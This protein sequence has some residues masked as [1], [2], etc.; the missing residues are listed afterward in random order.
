MDCLGE[1]L[2]VSEVSRHT[3]LGDV[4]DI[5]CGPSSLMEGESCTLPVVPLAGVVVFPGMIFPLLFGGNGITQ[6]SVENALS[7]NAPLHGLIAVFNDRALNFDDTDTFVTGCLAEIKQIGQSEDHIIS[8]IALGKQRIRINVKSLLDDHPFGN[9]ILKTKCVL[10]SEA[11]APMIPSEFTKGFANWPQWI[12][13]SSD[14]FY[15]ANI[16]FEK[17]QGVLENVPDLRNDPRQ[18]SYSLASSLPLDSSTRQQLLEQDNVSY[19]LQQE[20]K[21]M[22]YMTG[23]FCDECKHRLADLDDLMTSEDQSISSQIFVNPNGFVHDMMMLREVSGIRIT[24]RETTEHS[25]FPGYAWVLA[26]CSHCLT[27]IGWMFK[28][29]RKNLEP[30]VFWGFSRSQITHERPFNENPN[31]IDDG[32]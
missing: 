13:R 24:G 3:Y 12:A 11:T 17:A 18:F 2:D 31:T 20:I 7:A 28:A 6:R 10:L 16:A 29:T 32:N 14:P 8:A 4:E 30:S 21:I 1:V 5:S 26:H 23:I 25:W 22:S 27:H 9:R 19:R 15:L